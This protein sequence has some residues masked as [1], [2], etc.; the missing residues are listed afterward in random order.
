MNGTWKTAGGSNR[1]WLAVLAIIG[2]VVLIGSG[3]LTAA[4]AA[5]TNF[6]L[7]LLFCVLAAVVII[8]A[9]ALLIW[10]RH[11]GSGVP[12]PEQVAAFSEARQ[13]RAGR[14]RPAV[15]APA[16]HF[17]LHFHGEQPE[18]VPAVLQAIAGQQGEQ[19]S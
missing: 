2:A 16:Q 10:R 13:V 17:H 15:A 19:Q 14:E 11:G 12:V 9:A 5:I 18:G 7:V 1:G 6:L 8:S 4:V 3:A